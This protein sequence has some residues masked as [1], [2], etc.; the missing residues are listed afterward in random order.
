MTS[1]LPQMR[2]SNP[3]TPVATPLAPLYFILCSLRP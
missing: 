2:G 1:H 3:Q